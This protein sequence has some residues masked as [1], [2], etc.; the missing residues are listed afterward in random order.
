M[1]VDSAILVKLIVREPDSLYYA[2]RLHGQI[3]LW[4]SELAL[5]E[6]WSALLRKEREEAI[7]ESVRRTA[8]QALLRHVKRDLHTL[9]VDLDL[10]RR[11]NRIMER[12]HPEVAL[13][14]VDAIHLA[15]AEMLDAFP[16][17]TNDARMRAAATHLRLPLCHLP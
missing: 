4:S 1:Y 17:W 15:S 2:E 13:R 6:V 7:D 5:T 10:L 11:A 8:W 12:C 16:V 9:P 3:G 14:S